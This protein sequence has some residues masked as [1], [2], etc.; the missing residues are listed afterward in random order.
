VDIS[1]EQ[2]SGFSTLL[3]VAA[4]AIALTGLF[5]FQT[6]RHLKPRQWQA[7]LALRSV[8]IVL[9]VL[10]LFKPVMSYHVEEEKRPALIFAV[11]TSSSMGIT[12]DASNMTR[13]KK[14]QQEL[15]K[16]WE[17]LGDDFHLQLI[18]FSER[19]R[20]VDAPSDLPPLAQGK[21]TSLT[22]ALLEANKKAGT[23][24]KIDALILLSDGRDN[25][26]RDPPRGREEE[27]PRLVAAG[28]SMA[29][30]TIG[31]GANVRSDTSFCDID[32]TGIDCAERLLLK[33][34]A[35][36]T[37]SIR[38]T[39]L[40]GRVIKVVLEEDDALLKEQEL[41]LA[42]TQGAQEVTFEF[43]PDKKGRHTYTIRVDHLPEERIKENNKRS[44]ASLVVEPGMRVLYLEGK[45]R[46]EY[47]A[48]VQRFLAKDPDLQFY[49]LVRTRE[50]QFLKRT[51]MADVD[52]QQIPKDAAIYE[53]FN[54]FII[55]DLEAVHI[56]TAQQE[57]IVKRVREGAGLIMLGGTE[58]LGPGGYAGTPLGDILPVVLGNRAIGQSTDPFLPTLTPEGTHHP[59]FANIAGFFPTQQNP[60]PVVAGLPLLNGCTRVE[61]ESPSAAVLARLGNEPKAMPVLSLQTV[62]K[63]RTVVF[64]GD[65][66]RKWQQGPRALGQDSP[67]I[68]FWGQMVRWLAGQSTEGVGK[69]SITA[70]TNKFRYEAGEKISI[71]AIV[72]NQEGQAAANAKVV[73]KIRDPNGRP[74][75][76]PLFPGMG[77]GQYLATHEPRTAGTHRIIVEAQVGDVT[78]ASEELPVEVGR[79][80]LEYEKL[81]LND[82]L[83]QE[84][85]V[86]GRGRYVH[87]SAAERLIEQLDRSQ[88]KKQEYKEKKLYWPLPFWAVFVCVL[89][90]E[91]L[92]RKQYQL[93]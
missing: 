73:A 5:Y 58:T 4:A 48:L 74:D 79:P 11:D 78:V 36:V 21:A 59:I 33:N 50:D 22:R 12:D 47:G 7:L 89:T 42:D 87:L 1:L 17:K 56:P 62:G 10:L 35:T 90:L 9:I 93:R 20:P 88:R 46:D 28:M 72:R 2:G 84:I 85:A 41:T 18:E 67:Y 81:D 3:A 23:K 86:K 39:G 70:T 80:S 66:T 16:W 32:V 92:L 29:V 75:E 51:N 64:C 34:K 54:V 38:G 31:V 43:E 65:T 27:D 52:I 71:E 68:R 49:S 44:T 24:E 26:A 77:T 57:M 37:G 76:S 60:E 63:G 19:A 6:F 15:E 91:W 8:A 25:V 13:Y 61:R 69:A 45:L 82:E 55:G 14:V 53:K 30:H 83:L 40:A